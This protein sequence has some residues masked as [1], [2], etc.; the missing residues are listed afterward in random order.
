MKRIYIISGI[1]LI[2]LDQ[3]VKLLLQ[4]KDITLIPNCLML[5][6]IENTGTAFSYI[7]N[8]IGIIITLN[9]IIFPLNIEN[10]APV[11]FTKTKSAI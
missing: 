8:N 4:N 6:Y 3:L 9:I 7:Q 2:A 5:T 10:A 1:L 11:F